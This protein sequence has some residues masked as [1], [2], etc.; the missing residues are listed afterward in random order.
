MLEK[1][2][3]QIA[4]VNLS[5]STRKIN[6]NTLKDMHWLTFENRCIYQ[7]AVLQCSLQI[8]SASYSKIY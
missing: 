3:K 7:T 4:G 1:S 5:K 8:K 6:K 2:Q